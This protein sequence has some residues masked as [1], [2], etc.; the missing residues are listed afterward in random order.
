[1]DFEGNVAVNISK[2]YYLDFKDNL[3]FDQL[4]ESMGSLLINFF[5]YYRD[6][7]EIRIIDHLNEMKIGPFS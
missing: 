1:M 5:K 2:E 6:G 3:S 4:C 7:Q